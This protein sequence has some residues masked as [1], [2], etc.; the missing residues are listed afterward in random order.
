GKLAG[1]LV[2][3]IGEMEAGEDFDDFLDHGGIGAD[4]P[5]PLRARTQPFRDREHDG[6]EWGEVEKQLVDWNGTREP[7]L[8]PLVGFERGDVL[9]FEQDASGRGPQH[10]GEQIDDRCL[11]G[12]VR[13][14]QRVSRTLFDRERDAGDRGNAAEM[15]LQS[16]GFEGDGH[17]LSLP[18]PGGT[19]TGAAPGANRRVTRSASTRTPPVHS[20]MRSR[21]MSTIRTSTRPIQNCQYCGV[22]LAIQ[23][24]I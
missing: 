17:G 20:P 10:A 14:D 22:K 12:P 21:P 2:H 8:H 19:G 3:D 9:S 15:L 16:Y 7:A 24:C 23:S 11:A 6:L 13:S 18:A 4:E 5:P 1:A